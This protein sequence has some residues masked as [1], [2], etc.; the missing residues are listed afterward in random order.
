[1]LKRVW[2]KCTYQV[3]FKI[4]LVRVTRKTQVYYIFAFCLVKKKVTTAGFSVILEEMTLLSLLC[5]VFVKPGEHS[6]F[7]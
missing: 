6:F 4:L 7:I 1:M 3:D 2:K 5:L